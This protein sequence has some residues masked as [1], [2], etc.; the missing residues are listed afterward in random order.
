MAHKGVVAL[1]L[2]DVPVL[3]ACLFIDSSAYKELNM[4]KQEV[5]ASILEALHAGECGLIKATREIR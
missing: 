1:K 5:I 2:V 3:R 4:E